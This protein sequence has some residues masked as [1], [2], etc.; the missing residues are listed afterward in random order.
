MTPKTTARDRIIDAATELMWRDGYD[1]V[2]VDVICAA[3]NA[4]EVMPLP[5][6]RSSVT[7]LVVTS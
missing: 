5:Q 6:K 4:I 2:S 7:P 3:A 1:A